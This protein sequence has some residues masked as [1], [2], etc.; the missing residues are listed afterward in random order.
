[1]K[2]INNLFQKVVLTIIAFA[3]VC[4]VVQNQIIIQKLNTQKNENQSPFA[5][6]VSNKESRNFIMM[7]VNADGSIDVNVKKINET[8]N[9]N[10]EEV[11]GHYTHGKIKVVVQ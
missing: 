5:A 10:V 8:V 9:V 4:L 6:Q 11:G 1:M 3:A 2:N 7:P